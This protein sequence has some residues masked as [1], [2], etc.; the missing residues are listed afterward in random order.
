MQCRSRRTAAQ[1]SVYL[2]HMLIVG[3]WI[4]VWITEENRNA[5]PDEIWGLC[6]RTVE[7]RSQLLGYVP[8]H[9]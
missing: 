8:A 3:A 6:K 9:G 5:T 4:E 2:S 7:P 1:P